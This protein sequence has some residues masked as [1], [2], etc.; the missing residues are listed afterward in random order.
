MPSFESQ[1]KKHSFS[2]PATAELPAFLA[3]TP[4]EEARKERKRAETEELR[5]DIGGLREG[6]EGD[7][8]EGDRERERE[9]ERR[10]KFQE[11]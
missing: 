6:A 8:R 7:K 5:G 10:D 1:T 11:R 4:R 2:T 9:R 3:T